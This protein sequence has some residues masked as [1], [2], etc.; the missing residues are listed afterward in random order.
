MVGFVLDC[1]FGRQVVS[2]WIWWGRRREGGRGEVGRKGETEGGYTF[3]F[4]PFLLLLFAGGGGCGCL[5][6]GEEVMVREGSF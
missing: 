2:C 4:R 3:S 1:G 5:V 6:W